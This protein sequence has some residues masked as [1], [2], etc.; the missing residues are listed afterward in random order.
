M[1]ILNSEDLCLYNLLCDSSEVLIQC[2]TNFTN[3]L[4][5]M[6]QNQI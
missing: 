6:R 2:F 5:F 1:Y 3:A 4:D